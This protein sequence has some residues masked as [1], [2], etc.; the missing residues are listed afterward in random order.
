MTARITVGMPLHDGQDL[1]AEALS[2]LQAQTF[3]NFAVIISVDGNDQASAEACRPFLADSRFRMVIHEERLDWVGNFNWLLQ[4]PLGEF[5]CYRQHDDTTAPDFFEKLLAV[6][7]QRPDAAIVNADCR[8]FGEASHIEAEP[9]IEG[10]T[11][12]RLK[13]FIER[14]TATPCRGIIRKDAIAQ[15]GPVRVDEFRSNQQIFVWLAKILRW[16]SFLR[17]PEPIYLRRLHD[18]NY[19]KQ[20]RRASDEEKLGAWTTVFTGFLEA[21]LPTCSSVEE[22]LF[23]QHFILDRVCVSREGQTYWIRPNTPE[24]SGAFIRKCFERLAAEGSMDRWIAPDPAVPSGD[25][26]TTLADA[27]AAQADKHRLAMQQAATERDR[28]RQENARLKSRNAAKTRRVRRLARKNRQLRKSK[29]SRLARATRR[30][31]GQ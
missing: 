10:D 11:H 26:A 7:D 21:V 3:T 13:R 18:D 30:L 6:A 23:F 28:L 27:I 20:M 19:H 16:G 31:F 14:I 25:A 15:A 1:V 29:A 8:Y 5:F 22:R 4:Q 9:S 2:A 24:K 17:L 12:Q